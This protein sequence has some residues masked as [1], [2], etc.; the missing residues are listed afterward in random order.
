MTANLVPEHIYKKHESEWLAL[1]DA[2]ESRIDIKKPETQS[3][4][5]ASD[6]KKAARQHSSEAQ[7]A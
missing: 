5:I 1:K 6:G 3:W 7:P 4:N 2:L